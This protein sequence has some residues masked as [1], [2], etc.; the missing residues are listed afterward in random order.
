MPNLAPYS[1][2]SAWK[3]R[4]AIRQQR[5]RAGREPVALRGEAG[6]PTESN[7]G[8]DVDDWVVEEPSTNFSRKSRRNGRVNAGFGDFGRTRTSF[9]T[10]S[11][12]DSPAELV[13]QHLRFFFTRSCFR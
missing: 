7:G 11:G 4:V 2:V 3:D 10:S 1:R 8:V 6:I 9:P 13:E 12:R 5:V